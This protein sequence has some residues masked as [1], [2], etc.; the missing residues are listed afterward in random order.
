MEQDG[1]KKGGVQE[2][3]SRKIQVQ[4]TGKEEE[5]GEEG[6]RGVPSLLGVKGCSPSGRERSP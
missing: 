6:G 2:G 5:V 1:K 3:E 4:K